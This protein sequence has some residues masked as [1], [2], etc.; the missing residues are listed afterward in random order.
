VFRDRF[1]PLN[2]TGRLWLMAVSLALLGGG[3]DA[4]ADSPGLLVNPTAATAERLPIVQVVRPKSVTAQETLRLP[5]NLEAYERA[6]LYA[7]VTGYLEQIDVD[8]GDR[9]K[10]GQILARLAVPELKRKQQ[11]ASAEIPAARA[12]LQRA[13]A[14][15]RLADVT[16]HRLEGLHQQQPGAVA[17][18]EVDVARAR[19]NLARAEEAIVQADLRAARAMV[20]QLETM[21]RYRH[22][23]APFAGTVIR[24]FADVGALIT[25]DAKEPVVDLARTDRL[26]LTLDIP[27][28]VAPHVKRGQ[29]VRFT[30]DALP[31]RTF[32][33]S[34]ARFAGA[35][36]HAT[37]TMRTEID[38]DN[39][40]GELRAGMYATAY[41]DVRQVAGALTLP[42]VAL[43]AREGKPY[44]LVLEGALLRG[45]PVSVLID[46][47]VRS[48]VVAKLGP[49]AMVVTSVPP[50][51]G[52][53]SRVIGRLE[54]R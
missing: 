37:R 6:R 17:R 46:D 16:F 25:K 18:Q 44:I 13:Q 24:R 47:G 1:D 50:G 2:A 8:L 53:G 19:T 10:P 45:V 36:D 40:R 22:L 32:D 14:R 41:L 27:E 12:R 33:G 30:I 42:A 11:R 39:R 20:A 52:I 31:D 26:R 9:V 28:R 3:C 5:G 7:R 49:A 34:I 48:V 23:H 21:L 35:L 43:R 4:P 54:D 38:V 51:V 29:P 15:V